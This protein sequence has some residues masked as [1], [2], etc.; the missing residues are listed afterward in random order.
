MAEYFVVGPEPIV[1]QD[2]ADAIRANDRQARVTVFQSPTEAIGALRAHLPAA[3]IIHREP[4]GFAGTA[5]ALALAAAEVPYAFLCAVCEAPG[6]AAVL[7]SPFS[8]ATVAMM[9]ADLAPQR[10]SGG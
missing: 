1:A 4:E 10:Q 5:L 6:A 8:E 2:L 7:Q 9:L 3:V